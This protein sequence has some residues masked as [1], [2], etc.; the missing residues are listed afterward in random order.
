MKTKCQHTSLSMLQSFIPGVF[1]RREEIFITAHSPPHHIN[2]KSPSETTTNQLNTNN[3]VPPE[4]MNIKLLECMNNIS[5]H[6]TRNLAV[7]TQVKG[8]LR[9]VNYTNHPISEHS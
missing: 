7:K 1:P 3:N 9:N 2:S 6:S 5:Q 8:I 4:K